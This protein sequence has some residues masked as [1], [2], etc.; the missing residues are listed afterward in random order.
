VIGVIQFPGSCDERDALAAVERVGDG[1][2]VW[3]EETDL[4]GLDGVVIP[5]G[6]SYGDY[7]RAGAIARFSPAME[8]VG[9]FA[10]DGGPVLGICNGFQVLC[11][12]GL[13]PGALLP[14][15]GLRFICKQV[16]LV[17][18]DFNGAF[19][20]Q[21]GPSERLSVPIKHMSGRYFAPDD[22]LDRLEGEGRVAF[23]YAPGENPNGSVRDIAGVVNEGGNV[24]GLMPHPEHAVD[25]VTGSDDGL[26]LFRAIASPHMTGR[27]DA[28][29]RIS[30]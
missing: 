23:R 17:A 20:D 1:R 14:N 2:L 29:P 24:L 12:A 15:E 6:F 28:R 4:S 25:P 9:R 21:V 10:A 26:A 5:G 27:A 16:G 30:A 8:A 19:G 11:E 7:L 13:L 22:E 18:E 3:H